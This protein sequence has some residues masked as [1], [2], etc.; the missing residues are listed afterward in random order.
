M[1]AVVV[2][3]SRAGENFYQ[4]QLRQLEQ[5]NT[6]LI[7]QKIADKLAIPL[8]ELVPKKAYPLDYHQTTIRAKQEKEAE[9]TVLYEPLTHQVADYDTIFIGYP[10]W[11]GSFPQIVATFLVTEELV[12]KK[13]YPFCTHEGSAL[14]NS[15]RKLEELCPKAVIKTG[16]PIYGS[17]VAVA[18]TAIEN[19][20]S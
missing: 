6:A 1:K 3:F 12:G 7:A 9:A 4:G 11:W 19:W 2:Y 5:G 17:K 13:I 14:G 20:L 18:D 8:V 10:N 16:L 15:I